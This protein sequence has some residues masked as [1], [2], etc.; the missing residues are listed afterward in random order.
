MAKP[1]TPIPDDVA[2]N[3]LYRSDRTCCICGER[4][5]TTQLHHIDEDPSNNDPENLSV[6]CLL[7][8]NDTQIRGGF[9]RKLDAHQVVKFRDEWFERVQKRRDAADELAAAHEIASGKKPPLEPVRREELP[10]PE[11]FT[12]YIRT[13]PAIRKDVYTRAKPLWHS[14]NTGS[15]RRG[16]Y[17]VND[18]LEQLLATLSSWYPS[19]HFDGREPQDYFNAMT[20]SRFTWHRAH[21]E[22]NGIG[23]G[24]NIIGLMVAGAVMNDLETMILDMVSSLAIDLDEFDYDQ[25][26]KEWEAADV[27]DTEKLAD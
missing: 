1:R 19:Y 16:C 6:L 4:G 2:A 18:V 9:G 23:T 12:N 5:R 11:K 13:L 15:Q 26:K 25:W 8:H 21:L 17:D 14:A 10:N 22:P 24:G 27:P 20:A 7:C 3:L